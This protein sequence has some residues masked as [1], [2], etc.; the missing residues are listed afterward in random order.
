MAEKDDGW[1]VAKHLA[2]A[3]V[4]DCERRGCTKRARVAMANVEVHNTDDEGVILHMV[5]V[6]KQHAKELHDELRRR[7]EA[8]GGRTVSETKPPPKPEEAVRR[9]D[10]AVAHGYIEGD[11]DTGDRYDAFIDGCEYESTV[12]VRQQQHMNAVN[13]Q[14][15]CQFKECRRR[16]RCVLVISNFNADARK[17][18]MKFAFLCKSHTTKLARSY[19]ASSIASGHN[20]DVQAMP[21]GED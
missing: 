20:V 1:Q 4:Q 11:E 17:S 10:A 5:F 18:D 13:L 15:K 19:A 14:S 8:A 3:T 9:H 16:A 7:Y 12:T 6:C 21:E 2:R